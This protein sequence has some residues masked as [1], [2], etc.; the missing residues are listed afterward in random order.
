MEKYSNYLIYCIT[1]IINDKKY[2]GFHATNNINDSYMG[3]GIAI[4]RAYEKYG[5]ENFK[6]TILENCNE[7]NWEEREKYWIKKL[8][9]YKKGYNMTVGGEG[10][11]GLKMSKESKSKISESHKGLKISEESKSKISQSLKGRFPWN[12][13]KKLSDETKDKISKANTGRIKSEDEKT[14]I[15]ERLKS[16]NPGTRKEVKEKVSISLK[17]KFV[18]EN[19]PM[20]GISR[21]KKTLKRY[22]EDGI[23]LK[24]DRWEYMRRKI[25]CVDLSTNKEFI[26]DGVKDLSA[27]LGISKNKYYRA[28]KNP[29]I[30]SNYNFEIL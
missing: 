13:D 14:K 29:E 11:I 17:G 24:G 18:G 3:S 9:T 28:L 27:N 26:F 15:S 30:L 21:S 22:E 8:G 23:K 19:N 1:N 7:L 6:K 25:R 10:S 16:N 12:I 4:N 20:S 5:I 2:I